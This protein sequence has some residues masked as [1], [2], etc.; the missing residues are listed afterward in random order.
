MEFTNNHV[1]P[2]FRAAGIDTRVLIHDWNYGDYANFG[3]A[4]PADAGVRDDPLFG[5]IAWHGY[6]G[7]PAVGTQVHNQYPDVR[8]F[9]TEHS[10]GTWIANQHNEDMGDIV[11]Y[12]R[13]WSS[14]VV[15]WSLALNQHRGTSRLR[16]RHPC[17]D[18]DL[19]RRGQPEMD[20]PRLLTRPGGVRTAHLGIP[21]FSA[22]IRREH[23]PGPGRRGNCRPGITGLTFHRPALPV[24]ADSSGP[25]TIRKRAGG[26][27]G[28]VSGLSR[29]PP[30]HEPA[31]GRAR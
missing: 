18:L 20:P 4:V 29:M 12:T 7:D 27:S 19:H 26:M 13:N 22:S 15:K 14:S 11:N 17:P 25:L 24:P 21:G 30:S 6:F 28:R 9:S 1:Y 16:G 31:P 3:S 23:R 8:Q 10:G 5:G 2:A